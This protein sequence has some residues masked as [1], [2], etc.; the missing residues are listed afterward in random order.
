VDGLAGGAEQDESL[1]AGLDE[2]ERVLALRLE[3]EG[4]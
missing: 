2:E 1:D 4:R 3:V